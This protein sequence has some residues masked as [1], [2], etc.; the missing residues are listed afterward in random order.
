VHCVGENNFTVVTKNC[1][2][3]ANTCTGV[4]AQ[5]KASI[6]VTNNLIE[7]NFAQGIL[8]VESTYAHIEKNILRK[9]Y[10]AQIAF[11]GAA[12]CDTIVLKNEITKGRA[13]GIFAIES[14][15]AWI[16]KNHITSNADGILI[17]DACCHIADN[18]I[19]ENQRSGITCC[20]TSFPKIER[21]SIYGNIQSGLNLRDNSVAYVK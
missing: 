15:F 18:D 5:D 3:S 10:K 7:S 17:F 20:G 2:L 4:C 21:N 19:S 16:F 1:E 12:S 11:G 8:L 6:K 9:N 14:G 13:E